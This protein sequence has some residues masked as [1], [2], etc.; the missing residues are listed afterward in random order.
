MAAP[1]SITLRFAEREDLPQVLAFIR[2]LAEYEKLADGVTAD[3]QTLE[4]SLFGAMPAAE[5]LLAEVDGEAAGFALFFHNFS[6]FLGRRGL[7]LEDLYVSP[8]FRGRGLGRQ[9]MASLARLAVE[10]G[11]GRFE[12]SVLDWNTPAI[13]FYRGLG[14]S[15]MDE[16]TVQRVTGEALTALAA[17]GE[18]PGHS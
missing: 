11:C 13:K 5:V 4:A 18:L 6:T 17:D 1:D 2:E 14:A 10:R 12:W 7:Y 9:L 15:S 16:W 8:R 3:E